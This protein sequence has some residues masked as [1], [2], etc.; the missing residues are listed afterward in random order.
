[1]GSGN[2]GLLGIADI[3]SIVYLIFVKTNYFRMKKVR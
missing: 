3:D 2:D 1:M